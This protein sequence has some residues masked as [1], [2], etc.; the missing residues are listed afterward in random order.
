MFLDGMGERESI[1]SE[2]S[3][4]VFFGD[5][6][7]VKMTPYSKMEKNGESFYI[8][9]FNRGKQTLGFIKI[10]TPR[11]IV[12]HYKHNGKYAE[13]KCKSLYEAKTFLIRSFVQ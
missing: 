9:P 2:L 7:N 6:R 3:E 1:A 4:T 11:R 10:E 8:V 13:Q 5:L 12:F